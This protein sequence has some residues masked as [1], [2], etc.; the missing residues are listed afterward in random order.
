MS[1]LEITDNDFA[2][3]A[4]APSPP[5]Q[6]QIEDC[7]LVDNAP[8][9]ELPGLQ[10]LRLIGCSL[11]AAALTRWL[12]ACP[13][14]R[15]L[16][17]EGSHLGEL[18]WSTFPMQLQSLVIHGGTLSK[19]LSPR[20]TCGL[21]V[22]ELSACKLQ[23]LALPS[24][25]GSLKRLS[26]AFN[27]EL[28]H[29]PDLPWSSA[30]FDLDLRGCGLTEC[31][32][33]SGVDKVGKLDASHNALANIG[34]AI[35]K[36]H[37]LS[38]LRAQKSGVRSIDGAIG[39][40]A[41]LAEVWLAGNPI[42]ELPDEL[43]RLN[44]LT[45]LELARCQLRAWPAALASAP[46]L[47]VLL[48]AENRIE[49]VPDAVTGMA[50]LRNLSL[51]KTGLKILPSSLRG[52]RKLRQLDIS[53]NP[54]PELPNLADNPALQF[55]GLC[56][57]NC[58]D[59][60]SAFERLAELSHIRNISFTNSNFDHFDARV[61]SVPGLERIDVNK[62]SVDPSVWRSHRAAHPGITIWGA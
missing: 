28:G 52:L 44:T 24:S 39:S 34:P 40:L 38:I 8:P 21:Q 51:W 54:I 14:L 33:V 12:A 2:S 43:C 15:G 17:I 5:S 58:L 32:D 30:P 60:P 36:Y 47:E 56:G 35:A 9:R 55:L 46:S 49:S 6:L 18:S 42:D 61:L 31:P 1:E 59:W 53:Y 19:L 45:L 10:Q 57:L 11:N 23:E 62:T 29:C 22:I 16:E 27:P 25:L 26:L 48:L 7:D 3:L 13:D 37:S 41:H 50:N 4:A 20:T